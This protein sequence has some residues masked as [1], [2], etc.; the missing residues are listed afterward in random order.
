MEKFII[1]PD[2]TCDLSAEIR[3]YFKLE[4]YVRGHFHINDESFATT[5]DWEQIS[6]DDFYKTLTDKKNKVTSAP[7]SPEEYYQIFKKY[8]EQ[9]YDILSMSI[10]TK[11]SATHNAT[12]TAAKRL[13]EEFPDRKIYCLNTLRMSGSFGLLVAYACEL[14]N[15]GKSMDEVIAWLEENKTR[16]HQ[17]GP[18]DDLTFVARRGQISNGKAFMGNLVGIKPMGDCNAEGYVTVLTK[19][20]GIKKALDTTVAY[21][22][23]MATD[24]EDQYIFIMHTDR[25]KYAAE[26]KERVEQSVKCK[27]VFVSDVFTG[28]APNIGP[29]MISLYFLGEPISADLAKEKETMNAVLGKTEQ[30]TGN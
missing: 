24:I 11:I 2:I 28:C 26:L 27:G 3:E 10:S 14:K 17:M 25:D 1:L 4:D 12:L 7:A 18:I 19:V 16:V 5:L 23:A 20:K 6:R 8:F 22:K 21:L 9:G 13:E 15:E 30:K 29:G